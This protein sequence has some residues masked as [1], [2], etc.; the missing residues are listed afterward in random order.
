MFV[1]KWKKTHQSK[2]NC[3]IIP[4]K[5]GFVFTPCY[6]AKYHASG[7]EKGTDSHSHINRLLIRRLKIGLRKI[8]GW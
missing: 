8:V 5:S 7:G 4:S 2:E 3:V 6:T 1:E